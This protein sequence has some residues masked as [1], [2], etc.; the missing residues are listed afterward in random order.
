MDKPKVKKQFICMTCGAQLSS[1]Y[2][3]KVHIETNCSTVKKFKC[4]CE[5]TFLTSHSLNQ[6]INTVHNEEKKFVCR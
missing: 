3:L 2:N 1:S 6:H 5:A 4:V